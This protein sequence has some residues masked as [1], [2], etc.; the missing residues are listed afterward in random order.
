MHL[1]VFGDPVLQ[2]KADTVT[3]FDQ[4]LEQMVAQMHRTMI[5]AQGVGLAAPQVG[6]SKQVCIIDL[7]VGE[8]PEALHVLINPEILTAQG[9]QKGEEG[10]LSF[11]DIMTVV[12]RPHAVTIRYQSLQGEWQEKEVDGYL[13]VAFCHEIDH[14]NGVLMTDR[15]S[16]LKRSLIIKK[17]EKRRKEGTWRGV[18]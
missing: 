6:I 14:L 16:G 13:A 15:V 2:T 18:V 17:V 4:N 7:S 9:S 10:C 5:D 11:P 12:E 3:E 1:V 8:D